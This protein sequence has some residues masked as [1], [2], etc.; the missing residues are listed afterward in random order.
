MNVLAIESSCDETSAAV[1]SAYDVLSNV[2]STQFF[3]AKYGG[4]VPELAS[5]A[6]IEAISEIVESAL[7]KAD[8]TMDKIDAI[9]VT[10]N[11]G[12]IGSL[13]VGASYAKGLAI[14][15]RKPIIPVNHIEG[16]MFSGCLSDETLGFPQICLVVSG[17]HTAIFF[18]ESYNTQK[19]L[20]ATIDD[21]AGE[22]FD[23]IACLMGLAYPGGPYID[24]Y[25]KLGD[26][27][28]FNFPRS[29]MHTPD[30]DF[31]FS[32]LKTS[33]RYFIAQHYPNEIP[34]QDMYDIAAGVQEA[35][36][37]VL[38]Y[39]TMRAASDTGA[40]AVVIAGGVSANSGLREKMKA[41]ADKRGIKFVAPKMGYCMDNAAM[42]G[43]IAERKIR[44]LSEGTLFKDEKAALPRNLKFVVNSRAIRSRH[45]KK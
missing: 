19:V 4:V 10:S 31:S 18:V 25:S 36:T 1:V 23:K 21:A 14:K 24:R 6:H 30:Y 17:G 39:K 45:K 15:Y 9:A 32:G 28:R 41:A 29:M 12:L 2:I 42:I 26:P 5:R 43:F 33:V 37:D 16:H 11:P 7:E 13:V 38:V 27:K 44:E 20:G 3:H 22:A 34:E 40:K 8:F 35:I